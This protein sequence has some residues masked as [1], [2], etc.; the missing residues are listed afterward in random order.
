MIILKPIDNRKTVR[1]YYEKENLSF[2]EFSNCLTA[3]ENNAV[4]G[5]CLFDI[6]KKLT[7][8][9]IEPQNDLP[10]LDGI[11]RSTLHVGCERGIVDAAYSDTAPEKAFET[12]N[13]IKDKNEKSL[14][15]DKLFESCCGCK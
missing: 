14:K 10:L 8:H 9:K 2:T 12:L 1:N 4:L 11:L 6:D 3:A 13:F 15:V 7:V 5:Y